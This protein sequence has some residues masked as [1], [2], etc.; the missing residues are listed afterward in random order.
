MEIMSYPSVKSLL[1]ACSV[2]KDG[3]EQHIV[4]LA[5][6][7]RDHAAHVHATDVQSL[8]ARLQLHHLALTRDIQALVIVNHVMYICISSVFGSYFL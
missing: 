5:P 1:Q 2:A 6:L 8:Q 4:P 7:G 3:G